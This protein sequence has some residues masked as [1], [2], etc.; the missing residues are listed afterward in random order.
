MK[1]NEPWIEY[2]RGKMFK[3]QVI[4]A[5][6]SALPKALK[7]TLW[8]LKII[9]PISL[10]VR[11]LQYAGIIDYIAEKTEP[12]FSLVGLPG[13]SAI[14][15]ITSVFSPLYAALAVMPSLSLNMREITILALM[16]LLSHNMIVECSVQAKTGSSF[17]G[18]FT[19]RLLMSFVVAAFLNTILPY[20]G[21]SS[22]WFILEER[23]DTSLSALINGWLISSLILAMIMGIIISLLMFVHRLMDEMHWLE[24]VTGY[25]NPLISFFGLPEKCS[26]MWIVG[27]VVGLTYGG[28]IM[29][30]AIQNKQIT[31]NESKKLNIHL[32]VSHSLIE[33]TLIFASVGVSVGWIMC[34][35]LFFAFCTV[36]I[37]R[38]IHYI[39]GHTHSKNK[40]KSKIEN[41]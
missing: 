4:D 27:N 26:F 24:K 6:Q 8:L 34:T 10:L 3:Q 39:V 41:G 9:L 1:T 14:A 33:D 37:M 17:V 18:I 25:I 15:F 31:V 36:W 30:D 7:T 20:E 40:I 35:R 16:C 2:L 13:Q 12:L 19:F 28:A 5:L 38:G 11:F 23:E 22:P 32:A 21:Y 29:I